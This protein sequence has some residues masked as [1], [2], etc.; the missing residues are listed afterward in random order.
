MDTLYLVC[1]DFPSTKEGNK[2]RAKFVKFLEGHGCRVQYSVFEVRMKSRAEL[3]KV[4]KKMDK[5]LRPSDDAVRI[6]P[7]YANVEKDIVIKGQG[8]IFEIEK[9]YFF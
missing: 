9:A 1:Y 7:L 6:Y 5:Y 8:A 3:D 2:R 4:L